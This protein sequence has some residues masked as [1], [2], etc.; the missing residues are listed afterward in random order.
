[1]VVLQ[2]WPPPIPHEYMEAAR[3]RLPAPRPLSL[4][5]HLECV[6]VVGAPMLASLEAPFL[7]L[8]QRR[9][10]LSLL[11]HPPGWAD[12]DVLRAVS[13]R[14]KPEDVRAPLFNKPLFCNRLMPDLGR[15][16]VCS[17]QQ[18]QQQRLQAHYRT[19]SFTG[20][21]SVLALWDLFAD[22][23]RQI[24]SEHRGEALRREALQQKYSNFTTIS[25]RK[26]LQQA[27]G[28]GVDAPPWSLAREA[29][30]DQ[31]QINAHKGPETYMLRH[32]PDW[33]ASLSDEVRIFC[34][35]FLSSNSPWSSGGWV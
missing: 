10:A 2:A 28:Q 22:L 27:D 21:R 8:A 1:M 12:I 23:D 26:D 35:S 3:S 33:R 31:K 30:I 34:I 18:H 13:D 16:I 6:D 29:D 4:E 11:L 15:A 20:E 14:L 17:R 5:Q 24:H 19:R 32:R 7:R 25:L 9:L